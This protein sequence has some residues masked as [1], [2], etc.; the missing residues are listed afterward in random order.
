M[1]DNAPVVAVA[2]FVLKD[3]HK[4]KGA[5]FESAY[6]TYKEAVSRRDGLLRTALLRGISAPDTFV[7]LTWWRDAEAHRTASSYPASAWRNTPIAGSLVRTR[8]SRFAAAA[9]PS[10]TIT[11]PACCEYPMPTPPP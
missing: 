7:I 5:E 2:R 11:C 4:D 3:K 8:L 9:V 10:A 6:Q 1:T